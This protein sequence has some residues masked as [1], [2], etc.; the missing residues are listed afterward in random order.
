MAKHK[1]I[2]EQLD[3]LAESLKKQN[4]PIPEQTIIPT[5]ELEALKATAEKKKKEAQT[6][7]QRKVTYSLTLSKEVVKSL[8]DERSL[9]PFGLSR[10]EYIEYILKEYL[11]SKGIVV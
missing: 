10:S 2:T 11:K 1:Q 7:T 6:T 4:D 8:D 3:S 5:H 9:N